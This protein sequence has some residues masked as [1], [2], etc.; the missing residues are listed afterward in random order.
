MK[1]STTDPFA[2][3]GD[4]THERTFRVLG[5]RLRVIADDRGLLALATHAFGGLP[6]QRVLASSPRLTL[7]VRATA[8]AV[9]RVRSARGAQRRAPPTPR[10]SSGAGL[11]CHHVDA[12]NYAVVAPGLRSALVAISPAQRA[13]PYFARYEL[14]EFAALTLVAR[15]ATLAPLHAACLGS[16][17]SGVLVLGD[18]GAGKS[19]LCLRALAAGYELLSEDAVFVA[20]RTMRATGVPAF[21][22]VLCSDR[23]R[24]RGVRG[25]DRVLAAPL[26]TRRSG[27]RKFELDVRRSAYR[28]ARRALRIR[29]VLV[30]S[31]RP[32]RDPLLRPLSRAALRAML[33]RTQPYA[34]GQPGWRTLL[35][36]M[37]HLPAFE[38]RRGAQPDDALDALRTLAPLPRRRGRGRR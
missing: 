30:L 16:G 33:A 28:V 21:L 1:A 19:T 6:A 29:C 9:P 35:R 15:V 38:L 27:A 31:P 20:P 34:S 26:I 7:V 25:A 3:R 24:L 17:S 36:G 14:L 5:A 8:D 10:L 4:L 11:L 23:G 32:G 18:S 37:D 2:E 12:S 13:D 22:H